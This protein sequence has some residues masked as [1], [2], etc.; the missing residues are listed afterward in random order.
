MCD[1]W[2]EFAWIK[3]LSKGVDYVDEKEQLVLEYKVKRK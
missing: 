2:T 1:G 3:F